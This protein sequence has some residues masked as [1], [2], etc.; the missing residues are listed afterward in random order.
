MYFDQQEYDIRF[1]W[2]LSGLQTLLP[3]C[4]LIVIVDVFSFTT[5]VDIVVGKGSIVYPYRG[6]AS[7]LPEFAQ[8][9]GALYADPSRKHTPNSNRT[10]SSPYSLAPSSLVAMPAGTKFVLPSPNGSVLSAATGDVPTMAGCLRNASAVA[11]VANRFASKI[12]VIAAGERWRD[13][14][15]SLRPSLEDYIG[16]GA[17]ISGL[18]GTRSPEAEMTAIAFDHAQPTLLETLTRC[19]SGKELIGRGFAED[20][21]LAGQ[22]NVSDAVPVLDD[23]AYRNKDLS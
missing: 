10:Q 17:I 2:G 15:R 23:G 9:R 13:A 22:L 12:G 1:E 19:G 11:M 8:E 7:V 5:C 6:E 4:E 21:Q 14:N 20:V 18:H 16:A 3:I